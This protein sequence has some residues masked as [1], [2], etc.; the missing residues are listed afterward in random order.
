MS[1]LIGAP[2]VAAQGEAQTD[3]LPTVPDPGTP[4][5]STPTTAPTTTRAPSATTSTTAAPTTTLYLPPIPPE[6]AGDP[7][8]PFL[9]DPGPTDGVDIPIAQRS[10]DPLSVAVDPARIA[11]ADAAVQAATRQLE[12]LQEQVR[13]A[14]EQVLRAEEELDSLERGTR[15]AVSAA[16]RAREQL[17]DRAVTAYM[18]GDMEQ[19]LAMLQT[20]DLVDLGVARNYIG[21]VVGE[22]ER[23]LRR[24]ERLRAELSGD[25]AALADDLADARVELL[26]SADRVTPAF[27]ELVDRVQELQAYQAGA[28]A[29]VDGFV[30]PVAGEVEF[31]DSWGYPR[32]MGTAS[33]HWHQGTD[34]FATYG[35]PLIA[36]EN[37]VLDRIGVGSLGGNKLWV[38]GESGTEY[39]YAHLAAFAPGIADGQ[40][41]RAGELIGYVGDTG[42]ARGTSPHL[43]FEI[44]PGG[45]GPVN[46]YPLLKA[47]YGGRRVAP[48]VVPTTVPPAPVAPGSPGAE[49][50]GG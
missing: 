37:G 39:Y 1:V 29:Y 9:V 23:L 28:Q 47:A 3:P 12:Q 2:V 13:A 27:E 19:R 10:F 33:A 15:K 8:V 16:A 30:F 6:L 45:V 4:T 26:G 40:P 38:K 50:A 42:N 21:V 17:L 18:V 20:D 24:Y 22:N 41:V 25:H 36:S 44:H 5:S 7:R 46:P 48:A 35:T 49:I 32:M 11:A 34:I 43:H 14:S 31:I